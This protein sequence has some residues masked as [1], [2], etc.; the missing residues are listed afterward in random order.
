M[1][2]SKDFAPIAQLAEGPFFLTVNPALGVQ[3]VAEFVALARSKPGE[4]T[5]ASVGAG[6]L[7][8]LCGV[9][10]E[11]QAGIKLV[12]V[13]CVARA[14]SIRNRRDK[15]TA[16]L[17]HLT[18]DVLRASFFGLK[19]SA[20]LDGFFAASRSTGPWRTLSRT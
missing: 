18:V 7:P 3:S 14:R 16:L 17:H 12:H 10:F 20:G 9:L 2:I 11:R 6:S 1:D 4:L 15:L 19:K 5:Y 8:H 13:I